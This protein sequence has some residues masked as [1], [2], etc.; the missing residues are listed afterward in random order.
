MMM[1]DF[2]PGLVLALGALL[3]PFA[4]RRIRPILILGLPLVTLALVWRLPD[5]SFAVLSILDYQLVLVRSDALSRL[6]AIIFSIM[7]FAGGLFALNQKRVLELVAVFVYAGSAVGVVLAGDLI[8]LF[9]F[10]ETMALASTLVVLSV[11]GDLS[12]RFSMRYLLV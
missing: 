12:Y 4:G 9:F 1:S 5:G 2:P 7:T 10:W 8:S 6:F 11:G 3:L